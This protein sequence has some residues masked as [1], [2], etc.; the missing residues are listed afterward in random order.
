MK[1]KLL[2]EGIFVEDQTWNELAS[3]AKELKIKLPV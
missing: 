1:E 3:L 2:C